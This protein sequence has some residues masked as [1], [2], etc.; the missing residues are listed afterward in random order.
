[1]FNESQQPLTIGEIV[2][3]QRQV[4]EA[5][6]ITNRAAAIQKLYPAMSLA[7]AFHVAKKELSITQASQK[8]GQITNRVAQIK[9][10]IPGISDATATM[11]AVREI[12]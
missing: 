5:S 9:E 4:A 6:R 11:M 3:H 7:T 12:D 1:M 10:R 2:L 8:A